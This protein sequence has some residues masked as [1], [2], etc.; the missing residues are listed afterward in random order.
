MALGNLSVTEFEGQDGRPVESI[1]GRITT[2]AMSLRLRL[3]P[4][5]DRR[6]DKAP[7]YTVMGNAA[8]HWAEI[9]KAWRKN[10]ERGEHIGAIM[11]SLLF[12]DEAVGV[13]SCAAFPSGPRE[14]EIVRERQ[15]QPA[16][17]A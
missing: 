16:P 9:G 10:I 4:I 3:E 11:F 2:L 13:K 17:V 12:D 7:D 14:W 1:E 15:R 5:E 8:G 6:S